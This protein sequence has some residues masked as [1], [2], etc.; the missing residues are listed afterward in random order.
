MEQLASLGLRWCETQTK[1]ERH[2]CR[3][4]VLYLPPRAVLTPCLSL[5]SSQRAKLPPSHWTVARA[6]NS[7]SVTQPKPECPRGPWTTVLLHQAHLVY[8]H[9][10]V[11][12]PSLSSVP[13]PSFRAAPAV[14]VVQRTPWSH[15]GLRS[16]VT[17]TS[18]SVRRPP[19]ARG[20]HLCSEHPPV[21]HPPAALAS[22]MEFSGASS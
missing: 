22:Y 4:P 2:R 11:P 15:R 14:C 3:G 19:P 21:E 10:F 5:D 16:W 20:L 9:T 13:V 7:L 12:V 6:P 8:P 18:A 17:S 1:V